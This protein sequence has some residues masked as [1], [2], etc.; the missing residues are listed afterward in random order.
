MR[1]TC[2]FILG[3]AVLVAAA[4]VISAQQPDP[5]P[6]PAPVPEVQPAP[7]PLPPELAP[8]AKESAET[9][10]MPVLRLVPIA[11]DT[12]AKAKP[13]KKATASKKPTEKP[14]TP[15]GSSQAKEAPAAA[16]VAT[17]GSWAPPPPDTGNVPAAVS[18]GLSKKAPPPVD[19]AIHAEMDKRLSDAARSRKGAGS[20]IVLGLGGLAL[21]GLAVYFVRSRKGVQR[22]P[23]MFDAGVPA[24]AGLPAVVAVA[25]VVPARSGPDRR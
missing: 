4:A 16:S 12:A 1:T 21:I 18:P 9:T 6:P 20:W 19:P 23:T 8:P 22:L 3:I 5:Q 24:R 2:R 25:A 13:V 10:K 17:T 14:S 11:P 7:A 15:E